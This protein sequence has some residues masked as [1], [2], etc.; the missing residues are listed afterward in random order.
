MKSDEEKK[1]ELNK[2]EFEFNTKKSRW[3]ELTK[4]KLNKKLRQLL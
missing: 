4:K 2:N 1:N 3:E